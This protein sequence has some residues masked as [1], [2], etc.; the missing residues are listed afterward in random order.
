M[1]TLIGLWESCGQH[2]WNEAH[3]GLATRITRLLDG[4]QL[5]KFF[6]LL[7]SAEHGG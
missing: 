2:G 1:M 5:S 6:A 4:I 7:K 3:S